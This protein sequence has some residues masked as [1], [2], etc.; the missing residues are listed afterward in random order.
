[1]SE[2]TTG[3]ALVDLVEDELRAHSVALTST[4]GNE[5]LLCYVARLMDEFGCDTTLRWAMRFRDSRAPSAT[6][7]ERR[8]GQVGGFCDCEIFLN[9]FELAR[10]LCRYD[11]ETDELV[12]PE[13]LPS[14]SGVRSSSTRPCSNWARRGRW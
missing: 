14:C 10:R 5:C 2:D 3:R 9:G 4:R 13:E 12:G 6:A 1:M 8:L 7:L 11:P